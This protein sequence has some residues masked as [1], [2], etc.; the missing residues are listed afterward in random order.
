MSHPLLFTIV[1]TRYKSWLMLQCQKDKRQFTI[2]NGDYLE[3]S[4]KMLIYI[5]VCEK[6][7]PSWAYFF[8]M[9]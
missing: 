3:F 7:C 1:I 2:I 5:H 4:W 9:M 6:W 8:E